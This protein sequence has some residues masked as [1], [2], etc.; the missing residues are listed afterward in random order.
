MDINFKYLGN[1]YP[2]APEI[3]NHFHYEADLHIMNNDTSNV[4]ILLE[5]F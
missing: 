3:P 1:N 2:V 5:V 4:F